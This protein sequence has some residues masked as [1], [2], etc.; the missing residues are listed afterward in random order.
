[1]FNNQYNY[2]PSPYKYNNYQNQNFIGN[3]INVNR[4][5]NNKDFS[6]APIQI[7]PLHKKYQTPDSKKI[8]SN[9][10]RKDFESYGKL[11]Y[12]YDNANTNNNNLDY[13][14]GNNV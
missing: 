5:R 14:N 10:L 12:Q 11:H 1:M 2:H 6:P 8:N 7:T 3:N 9:N 13:M 4:I